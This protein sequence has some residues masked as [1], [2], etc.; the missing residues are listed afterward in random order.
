MRNPRSG[1][2]IVEL[3]VASLLFSMVIAALAAIYATAFGQSGTAFREGRAKAM[4]NMSMRVIMRDL[5]QATIVELPA[6]GASGRHLSGCTNAKTDFTGI[7]GEQPLRFHFCVRNATLYY[8]SRSAATCVASTVTDANCGNSAGAMGTPEL[9]AT[10]LETAVNMPAD[11]FFTRSASQFAQEGNAVRAAFKV[12]RA[13]VGNSKKLTFE[14][15][16]T[17][18]A[19]FGVSP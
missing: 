19:H 10:E 11:T 6:E 17:M 2:T 16:T 4:A 12:T 5:S 1:F 8:Y 15:D 3:M 7:K 9:L 13:P 18:S 14:V